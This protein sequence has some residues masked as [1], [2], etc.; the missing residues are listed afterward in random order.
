MKQFKP[1]L[2]LAFWLVG[3]LQV[4]AQQDHLYDTDGVGSYALNPASIGTLNK[5]SISNRMSFTPFDSQYTPTSFQLNGAVKCLKFGDKDLPKIRG[6]VGLKSDYGRTW[7][8]WRMGVAA[9]F[10][11][12]FDLGRSFLS[13][14]LAPKIEN[15]TYPSPYFGCVVLPAEYSIFPPKDYSRQNNWGLDAGVY[16]Y[17]E[18]FN[19]GFST[20]NLL[21]QN[22]EEYIYNSR[23]YHLHGSYERLLSRKFRLKGVLNSQANKNTVKIS[24]M[25]YGIMGKR[26]LTV[27]LGYNTDRNLIGGASIRMGGLY[28]GC[29]MRYN[30]SSF[31]YAKYSL[32]YRLAFE[33][34]DSE[35]R[36]FDASGNPAF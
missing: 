6:A 23:L 9:Q 17:N 27:G 28:L 24:T 1:Y 7:F 8:I 14:G 15:V 21:R 33:L 36:Q 12:Q 30:V 35:L 10:N 20:S 31:Y 26:E 16:W 3:S 29:F 11:L 34:F 5:L 25:L 19:L 18:R 2:I 4:F 13:I 22:P 32:E